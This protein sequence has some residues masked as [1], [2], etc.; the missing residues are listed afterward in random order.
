MSD[1][2]NLTVWQKAHAVTLDIYKATA[3]FPQSELY[4][5]TSQI[6]R[7]CI[8]IGSN[9]SEGCGRVGETEK[10]RFLQIALGSESEL[11]Y[12]LIL[13]QDLGFLIADIAQDLSERVR[14][15]GRMLTSLI[16]K[17]RSAHA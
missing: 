13:A 11:E 4:G 9:I 5:L 16:G 6:R 10:A 7:S 8:S 1:F 15:V 3:S 17:V 2:R 12:Q 14:D